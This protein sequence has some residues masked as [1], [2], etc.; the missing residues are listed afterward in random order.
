MIRL[1]L[2][3]LFIA[4]VAGFFGFAG[5]QHYA[6]EAA[7]IVCYIFLGLF[8]LALVLLLLGK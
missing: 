5:V 1:V 4:V 8:V 3:F 2:L 7:K 6:V